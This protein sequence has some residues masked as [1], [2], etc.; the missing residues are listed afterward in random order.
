MLLP[1]QQDVFCREGYICTL[2]FLHWCVHVLIFDA[3]NF[4]PVDIDVGHTF[5]CFLPTTKLLYRL[6]P[7]I[8]G[9]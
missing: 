2:D 6:K 8:Y 4:H 7:P 5:L 9:S 3:L 1:V